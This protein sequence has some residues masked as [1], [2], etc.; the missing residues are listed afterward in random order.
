MGL[1]MSHVFMYFVHIPKT[2]DKLLN[3]P[4]FFLARKML[5]MVLWTC[6]ALLF[7][8]LFQMSSRHILNLLIE[9]LIDSSLPIFISK[10]EC[11]I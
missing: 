11:A 1:Q 10:K 4:R 3:I 2:A 6:V 7:Q 8:A 5:K 9:I